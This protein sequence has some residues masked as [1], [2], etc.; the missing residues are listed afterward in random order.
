MKKIKDK[1]L[2]LEEN[3]DVGILIGFNCLKVI[4]L[5]EVIVGKSED[6]YVVWIFF[7]WSIVGLIS[8]L[9][10]F[11]DEDGVVMCNWIIVYEN[12]FE[13][14]YV[15]FILEDKIKEVINFFYVK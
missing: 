10:I 14:S 2:L 5:K 9:E 11:L 13:I 12:M 15:S 3:F 8:C 4:K 6:L 7:G 1:I